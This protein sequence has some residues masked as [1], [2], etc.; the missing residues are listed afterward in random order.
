M[1]VSSTFEAMGGPSRARASRPASVRVS[2][3]LKSACRGPPSRWA[4]RG[5]IGAGAT[6]SA[7]VRVKNSCVP[8]LADGGRGAGARRRDGAKAALTPVSGRSDTAHPMPASSRRAPARQGACSLVGKAATRSRVADGGACFSV[9]R[10]ASTGS[11]G[12]YTTTGR[13]RPL[14]KDVA[15][16]FLQQRSAHWLRPGASRPS[17]QRVPRRQLHVRGQRR[18]P[19]SAKR[20]RMHVNTARCTARQRRRN[21]AASRRH[22]APRQT[23]PRRHGGAGVGVRLKWPGV[24]PKQ[25]VVHRPKCSDNDV[26]MEARARDGVEHGRSHQE[27]AA[28]PQ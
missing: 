3:S 5:C 23:Q 6:T 25:L 10:Q 21:H 22:G 2:S 8:E 26:A 11:P 7:L 17:Q 13:A 19:A 4:A 28:S 1:T 9:L 18:G 27:R 24:R 20:A 14:P 16:A 12:R 15:N